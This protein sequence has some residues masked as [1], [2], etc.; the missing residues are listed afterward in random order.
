MADAARKLAETYQNGAQAAQDLAKAYRDGAVEAQRLARE[1]QAKAEQAAREAEEALKQVQKEAEEKL[2]AA[3]QKLTSADRN[4]KKTETLV[5]KQRFKNRKAVILSKKSTK[6]RQVK[7]NW[8]YI[9]EAEG[10]V[11][12]CSTNAKFDSIKTV[13]VKGGDSQAKTI[14]G[15]KS[16]KKYYFRMRAYRTIN[17]K[18]VYSKY[19]AKKSLKV[20]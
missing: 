14:K 11:I 10:Y 3:D 8:K 9:K 18:R 13:E 17:G 12:Q 2:A 20:R 16:G 1:A 6:K 15:L 5:A 4:L 19:S 7:L